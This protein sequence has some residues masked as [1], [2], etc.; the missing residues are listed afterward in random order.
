MVKAKKLA[1]L[2]ITA[3][4]FAFASAAQAETRVSFATGVD[5]SNGDY[6]GADETEIISIPLSARVSSGNWAVRVTIPYL[7]VTGPADIA[8]IIDGESG[9]VGTTARTDSERG[10]G[11]TTVSVE[12]TFRGVGGRNGYLELAARARL[13]SGDV[14]KGLGIGATDY[15][16]LAEIGTSSRQGG[17][18]LSAGYRF[19]GDTDPVDRQDGMQ[20]SVG[21]WLPVSDRVRVGG[22]ANW[23]EAS[24]EGNDDPATA[25]AYVSY[26]MT[27]NLRVTLT[28]SGGLSDASADYMT[29]IRF[30]WRPGALNR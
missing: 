3:S 28:A 8:D 5:Y 25:G 11:D 12:R 20:A 7:H 15:T 19:L 2:L 18:Y 21:G 4:M 1:M 27:E 9:S 23:R 14:D 17:A 16:A 10:F 26:R 29:G 30:T 13:S 6:G 24:I 22:F